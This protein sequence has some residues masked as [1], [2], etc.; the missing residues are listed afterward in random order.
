MK[1]ILTIII[2]LFAIFC[3]AETKYTSE[4]TNVLFIGNSITYFHSMPKMVQEML[5]EN[6]SNFYIE[7]SA[8]PGLSLAGH[9]TDI[10][11]SKTED[12][13]I[14]RKKEEGEK[15]E[16]EIKIS[17][18]KWDVVILQTGSVNVLI[19]E[20]RE[21]N[22]IKAIN[23]IKNLVANPKCKF[24]LFTTWA[25]KSKFP[26]Q[27]CYPSKTIDKSIEKPVC[28]SPVFNSLE[29]E[30]IELNKSYDL[31]VNEFNLIKSSHGSIYLEIIEK[32]PNIE[33]CEDDY[34]PNK[35]GA[36][37]NA[38]IFY[39][40]LTDNNATDII[41]NGGLNPDLSKLLKHI[42]TQK[43]RKK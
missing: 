35:I 39:Q 38:C 18:K 3:N 17:L 7:Q 30:F 32:H 28:C 41:Y 5:E 15:T 11:T 25:S 4:K 33:L 16:T 21:Y 10:I 27:Y 13:I 24:I 36:F 2:S 26:M 22:V 1:H 12:G 19:P 9:L 42:V 23:E 29:D 37:V 14:T 40:M 6:N 34:H 8:F 20:S 43:L 31:I